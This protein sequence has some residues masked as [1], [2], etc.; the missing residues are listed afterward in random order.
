M[1]S[2]FH[3]IS[4]YIVLEFLCWLFFAY[5]FIIYSFDLWL[6]R[7]LEFESRQ[8][9]ETFQ[10]PAL[11]YSFISHICIENSTPD[12]LNSRFLLYVPNTARAEYLIGLFIA[13]M[14]VCFVMKLKTKAHLFHEG[15]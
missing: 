1:C 14:S 4:F 9:S 11:P 15:K 7:I 6:K 12:W 5:D 10:H 13:I 3:F 2:L 8:T